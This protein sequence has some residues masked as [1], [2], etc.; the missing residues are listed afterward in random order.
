ME[1]IGRI[2]AL[3]YLH[4]QRLHIIHPTRA[5]T[6]RVFPWSFFTSS[7]HCELVVGLPRTVYPKLTIIAWK[8][9]ATRV[10]YKWRLYDLISYSVPFSNHDRFLQ[11]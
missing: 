1:R 2:V 7:M 6:I 4:T 8:T 10:T 9:I 5:H 11:S 3:L